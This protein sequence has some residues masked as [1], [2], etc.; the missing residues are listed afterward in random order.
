MCREMRPMSA[1]E[2]FKD[3]ELREQLEVPRKNCDHSGE[4]TKLIEQKDTR[5]RKQETSNK[6]SLQSL[7]RSCPMHKAESENNRLINASNK[8]MV[9]QVCVR[10]QILPWF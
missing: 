3:K 9:V 10:I 6:V 2:D 8:K 7:N 4:R 1:H 5:K